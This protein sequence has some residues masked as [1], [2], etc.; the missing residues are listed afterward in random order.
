MGADFYDIVIV[1]GG[2]VAVISRFFDF[3]GRF[4]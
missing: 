4:F 3:I 1:G 2:V